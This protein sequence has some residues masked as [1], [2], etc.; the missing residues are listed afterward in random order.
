MPAPE[1]TITLQNLFDPKTGHPRRRARAVA[2]RVR[3]PCARRRPR[4]CR[5]R[6]CRPRRC[7]P[8]IEPCDERVHIE[9]TPSSHGCAYLVPTL[10]PPRPRRRA[11]FVPPARIACAGPRRTRGCRPPSALWRLPSRRS[12]R[13]PPRSSSSSR[14][15]DATSR[16][17]SATGELKQTGRP[18][19]QPGRHRRGTALRVERQ[20]LGGVGGDELFEGLDGAPRG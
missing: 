1:M 6:R 20:R 18:Q 4:R 8:V 12:L 14:P 10:D 2:D 5:P 9:T 13:E 3:S 15:P 7:R 17:R 19:P 16:P 11:A